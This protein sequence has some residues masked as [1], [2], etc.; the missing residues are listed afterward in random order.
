MGLD[1]YVS[2]SFDKL[3]KENYVYKYGQIEGDL[4]HIGSAKGQSGKRYMY[5]EKKARQSVRLRSTFLGTY[6]SK[7]NNA[8]TRLNMVLIINGFHCLR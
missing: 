3:I 2:I 4:V 6:Y 8:K 7:K 5:H 1:K